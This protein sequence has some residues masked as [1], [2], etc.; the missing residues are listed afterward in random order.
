[1]AQMETPTVKIAQDLVKDSAPRH[2]ESVFQVQDIAYLAGGLI[3]GIA[4]FRARVL[5]RWAA[6]LLAVGGV[7]TIVL[8]GEDGRGTVAVGVTDDLTSKY[9]A[10]ELIKLATVALGIGVAR[11]LLARAG[12]RL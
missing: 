11:R 6:A 4:L 8:K 2:R 12:A 10:G 3:F 9:S 7:V 5:A 1:M